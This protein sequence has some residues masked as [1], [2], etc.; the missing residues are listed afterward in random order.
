MPK[1]FFP[2][3]LDIPLISTLKNFDRWLFKKINVE[4]ATP[5]LDYV[6]PVWREGMTWMPLYIFLFIFMAVNFGA[7]VWPWIIGLVATVSLSDQL[8]SHLIKPLVQRHRPCYDILLAPD[9][10]LLLNYCSSSF[11]FV[12]SHATNHFG[13]AFFI[14]YTLKSYIGKWSYLFFFWAASISYGQVYIG[15]HYPIDVFC[16]ALLGT[17]IG[18]GTAYVFNKRFPLAL[19][20]NQTNLTAG[21]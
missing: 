2:F 6:F 19:L 13:M 8:S 9:I 5:F 4:W 12:S 7:R 14:Y 1:H 20:P 3:I 17:G 16:G 21:T 18:C 15:V 10:R 11:S